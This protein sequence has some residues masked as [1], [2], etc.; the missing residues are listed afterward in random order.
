MRALLVSS[1]CAL[2]S[3]ALFPA[4]IP[5]AWLSDAR[6]GGQA[7]CLLVFL[8]G[9][10]DHADAFRRQGFIDAVRDKHLSVDIV[11]ADA[12]LG[13]YN[14][15]T[16]AERLEVDVMGPAGARGYQETWLAG[17]SMGGAGVLLYAQQQRPGQVQGALLMSPYLGSS[18][19]V[20][21]VRA[22]GGLT[23]WRAPAAEPSTSENY[24]RQLWRW[25]QEVTVKGEPGPELDV[26]WGDVEKL[27]DA[28]SLLAEALPAD[29]VYRAPGGHGWSTWRVIFAQWLERSTFARRC[30]DSDRSNRHD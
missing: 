14:R 8:P 22:A 29:Q 19:V 11:S 15:G 20:A 2:T 26:G 1:C 6:P 4:P 5:M 18:D 24:A 12:T 25:L 30:V 9:A 3:C 13:Y 27:A 16:V 21:E 17:T 28:D 23:Q 7:R 10:G